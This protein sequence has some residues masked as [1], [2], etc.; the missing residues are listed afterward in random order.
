MFE[1]DIWDIYELVNNIAEF[2]LHLILHQP[3][4]PVS[5]HYNWVRAFL[6]KP[7]ILFIGAESKEETII[8][9]AGILFYNWQ[10]T[11][12]RHISHPTWLE[13]LFM[14]NQNVR[15]CTNLLTGG[16]SNNNVF[17]TRIFMAS[18]AKNWKLAMSSKPSLKYFG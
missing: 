16:C 15:L 17:T 3:K 18:I 14:K 6:S 1:F 11:E 5:T 9:P 7:I 8:I 2:S 12:Q 10:P 13:S 4:L